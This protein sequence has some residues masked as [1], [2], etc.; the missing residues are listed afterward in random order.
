[1][2]SNGLTKKGEKKKL[3]TRPLFW[4]EESVVFRDK[5][6]LVYKFV[7]KNK[8]IAEGRRRCE[9]QGGF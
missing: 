4:G 1:M 5:R 8:T 6:A 7:Q 3:R 9:V 2:G